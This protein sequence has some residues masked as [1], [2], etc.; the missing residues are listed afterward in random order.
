MRVTERCPAGALGLAGDR[1]GVDYRRCIHCFRCQRGAGPVVEWQ[2]SY[3]WGTRGA[4]GD[5]DRAALCGL[6]GA[7]QR[8]LHI[9]VVD[10]GACGACLS[11]IEQ[12]NKPYYNMHR[13]GFFVTPT[14]RT[15]DVLLLAG[16]LTEHMRHP[17]SRAYNAMPTPKRV[18]A[19]GTCALSGG[20]FGPGFASN[21][22]VTEAVP[23]DVFVPGCPPPPLAIIHALLLLVGRTVPGTLDSVP[24]PERRVTP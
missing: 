1:I 11:E 14:P 5:D 20:P 2:S 16:P 19:V 8:S 3:E 10:C 21:A 13:L 17:L 15:A 22:G 6:G 12:T 24:P 7:F 4:A 18:I 9:R 23:V